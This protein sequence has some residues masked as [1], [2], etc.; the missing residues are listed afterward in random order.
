[1][2]TTLLN[3]R[4]NG[5][6]AQ[7]VTES[8]HA[9]TLAITEPISSLFTIEGK[10]FETNTGFITLTTDVE[11]AVF[12]LKNRTNDYFSLFSVKVGALDSTG[13]PGVAGVGHIH[14]NPNAGSLITGG[15]EIE[16]SLWNRNFDSTVVPEIEVRS[17]GDGE[18]ISG[19]KTIVRPLY[20]NATSTYIGAGIVIIGPG[21]SFAISVTPPAGNTSLDVYVDVDFYSASSSNSFG[22]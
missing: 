18:T 17:G 2:E 5:K 16:G 21:S 3:G 15:T 1:M 11:T 12:Y 13:A 22:A 9:Q 7:S 6:F 8:G 10:N 4:G 14:R 20:M 19:G